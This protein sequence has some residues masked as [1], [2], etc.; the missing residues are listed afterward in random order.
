M[1]LYIY[2]YIYLNINLYTYI[3]IFFLLNIFK[4]IPLVWQQIKTQIW[5]RIGREIQCLP[6]E[7]FFKPLLYMAPTSEPIWQFKNVLNLE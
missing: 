1:S 7:G 3:Y 4:H 2:I 6:Y 5:S